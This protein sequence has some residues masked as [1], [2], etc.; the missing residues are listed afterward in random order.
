MENFRN[1]FIKTATKY[2][3]YVGMKILAVAEM[4]EIKQG[5][6][7]LL[8]NQLETMVLCGE[9]R[10]LNQT[11][12]IIGMESPA[13]DQQKKEQPQ[14]KMVLTYKEGRPEYEEKEI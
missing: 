3:D 8:G 5:D 14:K 4:K 2:A 11:A 7:P 12:E 10:T 1:S 13:A 9:M 6:A